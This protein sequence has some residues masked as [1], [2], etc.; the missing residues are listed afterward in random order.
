MRRTILVIGYGSIIA[1]RSRAFPA[2]VAGVLFALI[3]IFPFVGRL[4]ALGVMTVLLIFEVAPRY[5]PVPIIVIGFLMF[6]LIEPIMTLGWLGAC[7][8]WYLP[9]PDRQ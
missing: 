9:R 6:Y 4:I 1:Y 5:R 7:A 3:A 2:H 8:I